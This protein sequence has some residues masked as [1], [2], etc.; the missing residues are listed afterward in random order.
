[1]FHAE[2]PAILIEVFHAFPQSVQENSEISRLGHDRYLP[3]PLRF[4][5]WILNYKKKSFIVVTI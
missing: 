5:I 3:N 1:M 4:V 2:R